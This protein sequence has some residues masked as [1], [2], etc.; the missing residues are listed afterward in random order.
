MVGVLQSSL[1]PM[2]ILRIPDVRESPNV[3]KAK[4]LIDDLNHIKHQV[5]DLV[6]SQHKL[7]KDLDKTM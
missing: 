2:T 7:L 5:Q 1:L 6:E 4:T 3:K